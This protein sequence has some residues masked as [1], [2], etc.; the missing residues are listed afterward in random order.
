MDMIKRIQQKIRFKSLERKIYKLRNSEARSL[1]IGML[2]E[3]YK[4]EAR[5]DLG[6]KVRKSLNDQLEELIEYNQEFRLDEFVEK[7]SN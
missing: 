2:A 7:Y 1:G 5:H 4:T 6:Y 3:I